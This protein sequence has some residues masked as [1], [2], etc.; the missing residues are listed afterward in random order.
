MFGGKCL[1]YIRQYLCQRDE[2]LTYPNL[3]N[4]HVAAKINVISETINI[5]CKGK[6]MN[7]VQK[8]KKECL[9]NVN[10]P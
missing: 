9:K 2:Y 4:V 3:T 6:R 8:Y 10:V 1:N 5:C 7:Y